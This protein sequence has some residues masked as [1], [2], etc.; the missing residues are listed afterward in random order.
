MPSPAPRQWV[1]AKGFTAGMGMLERA[2]PTHPF[3]PSPFGGIF[4]FHA[5]DCDK[6]RRN[7]VCKIPPFR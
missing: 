1:L 3:H 6:M 4:A 2:P 5:F 7:T